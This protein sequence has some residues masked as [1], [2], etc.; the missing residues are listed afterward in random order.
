MA[1][2]LLLFFLAGLFQDLLWTLTMRAVSE[3]KTYHAA[4]LSFINNVSGTLVFYSI[5]EKIDPSQ[6]LLVILIFGLGV[7]T[8]TIVGMEYKK[9]NHYLKKGASSVSVP[10]RKFLRNLVYRNAV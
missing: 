2:N 5:F 4:T 7:G 9:L 8:G 3:R 6:S 10:G 1:T